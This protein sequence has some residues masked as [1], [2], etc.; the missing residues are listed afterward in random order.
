[1][2]DAFSH[3]FKAMI[4]ALTGPRLE[5]PMAPELPF[6]YADAARYATVAAVPISEVGRMRREQG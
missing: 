1:V 5:G 6:E 2:N 3:P 4:T